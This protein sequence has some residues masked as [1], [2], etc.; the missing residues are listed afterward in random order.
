MLSRQL[1]QLRQLIRLSTAH[2]PNFLISK[3]SIAQ[4][5]MVT[6]AAEVAWW[7]TPSNIYR[8]SSTWTVTA[9]LTPHNLE[10]VNMMRMK[11]WQ[12]SNLIN[13]F[14]VEM[15]TVTWLL[16]RINQSQLPF[17]Q[18]PAPSCFTRAELSAAL[19]AEPTLIMPLTS[20]VM[21]LK[22]E[23]TSGSSVTHGAPAGERKAT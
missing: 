15:L 18:Y 5:V 12:K 22:M 7:P 14:K 10:V 11:V 19:L 13:L 1:A 20:S 9:T 2:C 3:S 4:A 6:Q 21:G 8:V 16:C 17:L 23:R